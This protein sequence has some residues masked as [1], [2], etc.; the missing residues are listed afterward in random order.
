MPVVSARACRS[1]LAASSVCPTVA[2]NE[3][4]R[5]AK[6]FTLGFVGV[7]DEP[8]LD[9]VGRPGDRGKRR[10]DQAAGTAFRRGEG[11]SGSASPIPFTRASLLRTRD[12][13]PS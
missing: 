9:H 3:R 5:D 8:T 10:G 1:L 13:V 6:Q 12:A 4:L 2:G 11:Q 7:G